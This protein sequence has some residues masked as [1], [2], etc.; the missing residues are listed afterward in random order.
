MRIMHDVSYAR[1]LFFPEPTPMRIILSVFILFIDVLSYCIIAGHIIYIIIISLTIVGK[2]N[3]V[4]IIQ[5]PVLT[6]DT[7]NDCW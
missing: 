6:I 3:V 1:N 4:I 5:K 7:K 2:K